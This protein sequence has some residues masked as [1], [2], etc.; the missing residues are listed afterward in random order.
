MPNSRYYR[1][2]HITHIQIAT[3]NPGGNSN[4]KPHI[5]SALRIQT[6]V[7]ESSQGFSGLKAH[8]AAEERRNNHYSFIVRFWGNGAECR[9][10]SL[11]YDELPLTRT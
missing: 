11:Q 7:K 8:V 9:G 1:M 5:S 10:M 2:L 6:I 3:S 4:N